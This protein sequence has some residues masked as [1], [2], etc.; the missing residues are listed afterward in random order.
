MWIPLDKYTSHNPQL[1]LPQLKIIG[2]P[3]Q[4]R[5]FWTQLYELIGKVEI[6]I[7]EIDFRDQTNLILRTELGEIH[8]GSPN[9]LLSE[10]IQALSHLRKLSLQVPIQG[11]DYINLKN[12]NSPIIQMNSKKRSNNSQKP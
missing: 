9:T 4:Y 8:L 11:I 1:Q 2:F 7:T 12:P 6:Q 10:K 5:S 3:E